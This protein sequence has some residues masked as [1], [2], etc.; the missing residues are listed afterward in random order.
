MTGL[1]TTIASALAA[2]V[3]ALGSLLGGSSDSKSHTALV[4]DASLG[5]DGRELVDPR[6]RDLDAELRLP[7][8]EAEAETDL[9][10]FAAQGYRLLVAGPDSRAAAEATGLPAAALSR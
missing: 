1:G 9:R 2:A 3:V 7:R 10:Y 4:I 8:T 6:L 5:R